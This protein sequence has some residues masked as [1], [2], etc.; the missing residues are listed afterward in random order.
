M[1]YQIQF[2]DG[3]RRNITVHGARDIPVP[4]GGSIS[5]NPE[6]PIIQFPDGDLKLTSEFSEEFR[7]F[8]DDAEIPRPGKVLRA[9]DDLVPG[10]KI[11]GI[12]VVK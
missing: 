9:G 12:K 1:G 10:V 11:L 3:E 8:K 2:P 4:G 5:V 7:W 6:D